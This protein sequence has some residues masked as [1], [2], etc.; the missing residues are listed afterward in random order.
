MLT[1]PAMPLAQE[2]SAQRGARV[3]GWWD[4]TR[5]YAKNSN[6]F[7]V[8]LQIRVGFICSALQTSRT[9]GVCILG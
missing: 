2:A 9:A 6:S 5:E 3:Y 4:S 1:P 7:I 8:Y